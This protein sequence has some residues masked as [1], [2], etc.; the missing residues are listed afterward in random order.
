M[1]TVPLATPVCDPE[2]G[3]M[4]ATDVLLLLH[5]PPAVASD[6]EAATPTQPKPLPE[7]SSGYPAT[8]TTSGE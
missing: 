3:S 8:T 1:V 4:V 5:T 6:N 2:A 7:K